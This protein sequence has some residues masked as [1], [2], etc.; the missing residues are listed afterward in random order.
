MKAVM[1]YILREWIN[2]DSKFVRVVDMSGSRLVRVQL[3]CGEMSMRMTIYSMS[4]S[5][6]RVWDGI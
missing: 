1:G 3:L 4:L 2:H 5:G 6:D